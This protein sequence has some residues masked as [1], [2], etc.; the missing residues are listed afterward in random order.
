M[1]MHRPKRHSIQPKRPLTRWRAIRAKRHP[2]RL[3]TPILL[4]LAAAVLV[5]CGS[6]GKGLI[7]A[8]AAGPLQGDFEAIAQAANGGNGDCT[9]TREAIAKT[10][11]DFIALPL[12]VDHGLR[13]RIRGGIANLSKRAREICVQPAATT[14]VTS[15]SP[16]STSSSSST[17]TSSSTPSTTSTTTQTTTSSAPTVSTT[18][19]STSPSLGGGTPAE[20]ATPPP[21]DHGENGGAGEGNGK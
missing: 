16:A 3:L 11:Q 8:S 20:G 15:G 21:S 1:T 17:T 12:T 19:T 18:A 9:A 13:E 7:P 10:E 14:T 4:G 6:S 2:I 5:A